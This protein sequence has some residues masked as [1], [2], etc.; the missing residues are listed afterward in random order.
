M[1]EAQKINSHVLGMGGYNFV[2]GDN[3]PVYDF[4]SYEDKW[5]KKS[6]SVWKKKLANVYTEEEYGNIGVN[7]ANHYSYA[8]GSGYGVAA[9]LTAWTMKFKC[10][11][12]AK[13]DKTT[14]RER[15]T[16]DRLLETVAIAWRLLYEGAGL[17]GFSHKAS[18]IYSV[19]LNAS[20]SHKTGNIKYDPNT[21]KDFP[22]GKYHR[23]DAKGT[24]YD[25][26][27]KEVKLQN[28]NAY[29]VL[30]GLFM[31]KMDLNESS[32]LKDVHMKLLIMGRAF[33]KAY[34]NLELYGNTGKAFKSVKN[35]AILV[36][37]LRRIGQ[38]RDPV[39]LNKKQNDN[40]DPQFSEWE[41]SQ[42]ISMFEAIRENERYNSIKHEYISNLLRYGAAIHIHFAAYIEEQ[43]DD[44]GLLIEN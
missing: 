19:L 5:G 22:L 1:K 10:D 23:W 40:T 21:S 28:R 7:V 24:F 34:L 33:T 38:G 39:E 9:A 13:G 6:L 31:D 27:G 30:L 15:V 44:D 35:A 36:G 2:Y 17:S 12:D 14:E 26:K 42:P 25:D 8:V 20:Y 18:M 37:A 32:G 16:L 3:L 43:Q 41:E 29:K 4:F 11:L